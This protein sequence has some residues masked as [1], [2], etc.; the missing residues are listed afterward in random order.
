M[1]LIIDRPFTGN[2][3]SVTVSKNRCNQYFVSIL[4]EEELE[5]KQN[6]GR[7]IGIDLGLNHL[8][9]L[10]NGM[11]IDNPRWF[12]E[13]QAKLKKAQQHLSRK[14]KGSNRYSRQRIKVARIYQK[15][16]NQRNFVHHNLSTWLVSNYDTI[17][18]EKLNVKGMIKN[19]R[20]AKS[21]QDA[22]W[23]TLVSM[24][25]YK[26]NWYGKTF[27]RIDTFYPSSKTCYS[28]GYKVEKM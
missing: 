21:I 24:I 16:S 25:A 28:C 22:S 4:V 18:T 10:S 5:L 7:S 14:T 17:C 1:K 8:A 12:R 3:K 13:S 11:K 19:R 26:A 20:I 23:S 6:T 27:Q 9:I 2:L 15:I